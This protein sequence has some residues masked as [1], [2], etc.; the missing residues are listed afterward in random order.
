MLLN[1]KKIL[2]KQVWRQ[3][4][5]TLSR[6]LI[7][8]APANLQQ[9]QEVIKTDTDPKT[10]GLDPST[11]F[12][13]N[14][15][16]TFQAASK[17]PARIPLVKSMFCGK[18]DTDLLAYPECISRDDMNELT[19]EVDAV[20]AYFEQTLDSPAILAEKNIPQNVLDELRGLGAFGSNVPAPLGGR[21][22]VETGNAFN[23]EAEA[24]DLNV[25]TMLN[26]HRLVTQLVN[27]SSN[28]ALKSKY[29]PRLAR[30]K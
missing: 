26:A 17:K 20:R 13:T 25:A 27:E 29:L 19:T 10:D 15:K 3:S 1:Y 2:V 12:N 18:V 5:S 24:E 8:L 14:M 16:T 23:G 4:C 11:A 6:R 22:Y 21:G 9:K 7:S 30:G 28:D